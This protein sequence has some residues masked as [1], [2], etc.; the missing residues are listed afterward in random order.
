V[1]GPVARQLERLTIATFGGTAYGDKPRTGHGLN[2]VVLGRARRA[3]RYYAA[4]NLV[5]TGIL[6]PV[7]FALQKGPQIPLG[8]AEFA[9]IGHSFLSCVEMYRFNVLMKMQP[10]PGF[11][12]ERPELPRPHFHWFYG[13]YKWEN[14]YLYYRLGADFYRATYYKFAAWVR[15]DNDPRY[16]PVEGE[17]VPNRRNIFQ[18]L[19]DSRQSELTHIFGLISDLPPMI[20]LL[21]M[22]SPAMITL[23]VSIWVDFGIII[24]SRQHRARFR[25]FYRERQA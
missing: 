25:R 3:A 9:L 12:C 6:I 16:G 8:V 15:G 5:R 14:E 19:Y 24:L 4:G 13:P 1:I 23:G 17:V 18:V 2:E 10:E 22:R 11:D 7:V 21:W 20:A